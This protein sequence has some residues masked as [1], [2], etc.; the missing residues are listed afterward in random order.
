VYNYFFLSQ[1]AVV[2]FDLTDLSSLEEAKVWLQQVEAHCG[3]ELP[4]VLLGNK[5]DLLDEK[6]KRSTLDQIKP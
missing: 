6:A 4:K 2:V 5:L 3:E 1:A